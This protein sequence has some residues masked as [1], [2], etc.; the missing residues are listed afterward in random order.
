MS[1]RPLLAATAAASALLIAGL[2]GAPALAAGTAGSDAKGVGTSTL[3][4]LDL[5]AGG[6]AFT[7]GAVSLI[8]D[9]ATT[10]SLAKANVTPLIADG[11]SYGHREV[12]PANSPLVIPS[13]TSPAALAGVIS[14]TTPS[15][16]A[17]A[18]TSPTSN[19]GTASLGSV[20]LLGIDIPI[21]GSALLGTAVTRTSA[22]GQKTVS[23]S[24][25]SLPSIAAILAALGIDVTKLPVGTVSSLVN[26]LDIANAAMAA[27]QGA[28]DS[29][30]AQVNTATT[31][32]TTAQATLAAQT[33]SNTA[34][35]AAAASALSA[36]QAK[37]AAVAPA[38]VALYS[39]ANTVAG[40]GLL[41][42]AGVNAVEADSPGTAAAYSAYTA[43]AS[44]A[45]AAAAQ[46]ATAQAAVDAAQAALAPLT[47]ALDTA[48]GALDAAAAPVLS[49]TPL[50]SL[51]KLSIGTATK[52]TSATLSGQT[53]S[54]TG[55]TVEGLKV[56][57]TDVLQTVLG[58]TKVD[59]LDIVGAQAASVTS[60]INGLTG[61]LSS[62]LSSVSGL[63]FPAPKIGLLTPTTRTW[64]EDGFG[65]ALASVQGLSITLPSITLP[66][67]LA[68]PGAVDLPALAGVTQVTGLLK[69]APVSVSML[70]I[71][72][73]SA[74]R[75]AV[76]PGTDVGTPQLPRTG[77]P[78]GLSAI[79]V[80]LVGAGLIA[81]R[82]RMVPAEA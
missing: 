76:I 23:V 24:G 67:A 65:R 41:S 1:T 28:V 50:V 75:P 82:R 53:A 2:S 27:A 14:V 66:S 4:L 69:S 12:T 32:L 45:S 22:T 62:V 80:L 38:T 51:G 44:A 30:Q 29:A 48:L 17:S 13:V 11:V 71:S 57:G 19:A 78:A 33:A 8:S 74:F 56:L 52:S 47:A 5:T 21:D 25:V 63:S 64:V 36:L 3:S 31:T 43:A 40:Y 46:V 16:N 18:T 79:A 9:T 77:T 55:G 34:A 15:L 60:T 73:Q 10:S 6:H 37:L 70:S 59:L 58:N 54:I 35:Q 39:G 68:L 42:S 72:D 81:R 7:V 49:S 20:K 26:A 61:T